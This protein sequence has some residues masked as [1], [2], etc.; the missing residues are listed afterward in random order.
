MPMTLLDMGGS[1]PRE[2]WVTCHIARC[3][4]PNRAKNDDALFAVPFFSK[5]CIKCILYLHIALLKNEQIY[6]NTRKTKQYQEYLG[7]AN[8][9]MT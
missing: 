1:L 5:D 2:K 4:K 9:W 7:R 6:E 3:D 8:Q